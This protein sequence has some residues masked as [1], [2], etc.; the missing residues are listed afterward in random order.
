MSASSTSMVLPGS[1]WRDAPF[2]S[3]C[4]FNSSPDALSKRSYDALPRFILSATWE[5]RARPS[6]AC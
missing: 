4:R 1:A 6:L 2:A 5:G 3:S